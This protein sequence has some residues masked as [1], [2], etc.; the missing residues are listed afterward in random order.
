M[1]WE[2][3][4]AGNRFRSKR[5]SCISPSVGIS[6][7]DIALGCSR[8]GILLPAFP[9]CLSIN[10]RLLQYP[11]G[12]AELWSLFQL[13]YLLVIRKLVK[14]TNSF[15]QF[16]FLV[17]VIDWNEHLNTKSSL[18]LVVWGLLRGG[19]LQIANN[20]DKSE[21]PSSFTYFIHFPVHPICHSF[22]LV[23]KLSLCY[24]KWFFIVV[25]HF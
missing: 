1:C 16:W 19:V 11:P 2:T 18:S 6:T 4:C 23:Y 25:F 12:T 24:S 9:F 8:D 20:W 17:K 15:C 3:G 13:T 10:G 5:P 22:L 7:S 21:D 14:L